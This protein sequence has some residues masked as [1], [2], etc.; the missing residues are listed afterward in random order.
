MEPRAEIEDN[1]P[2]MKRAYSACRVL[3]P[4]APGVETPGYDGTRLWRFELARSA[5]RKA[6][7]PVPRSRDL[8]RLR[9]AEGQGQ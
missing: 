4:S 9:S 2:R 7:R 1:R 5:H 3:A 6:G 8:R